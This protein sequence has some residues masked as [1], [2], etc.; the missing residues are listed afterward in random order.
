MVQFKRKEES[1]RRRSI[2]L[3]R[4]QPQKDMELHKEVKYK[5]KREVQRNKKN[6]RKS[7]KYREKY[8]GKDGIKR[9]KRPNDLQI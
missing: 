6:E 9:K 4:V 5:C 8:G 7:R 1:A 3:H 2:G